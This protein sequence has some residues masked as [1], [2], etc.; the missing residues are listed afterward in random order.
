VKNYVQYKY[1]FPNFGKLST[2]AESLRVICMNRIIKFFQTSLQRQLTIV[3]LALLLIPLAIIF[4]GFA[5]SLIAERTS[6]INAEQQE[7]LDDS[8]REIDEVFE[9]TLSDIRV[10][11][12]D[13][14]IVD[15]GQFL[16][17]NDVEGEQEL[18]E[19][20]QETFVA[21][22]AGREY[23]RT[24]RLLDA[25][26]REIVRVDDN[27]NGEPIIVPEN[28]LQDKSTRGYY[29]NARNLPAGEVYIGP[30][31]LVREEDGDNQAIFLDENGQPTP[32][33][34]YAAPIYTNINGQNQLASILVIQIYAQSVLDVFITDEGSDKYIINPEGYFLFNTINPQFNFG[35]ETDGEAIGIQVGTTLQQV[36]G[37]QGNQLFTGGTTPQRFSLNIE[38]TNSILYA[39]RFVPE[40]APPNYYFIFATSLDEQLLF[41][42][43]QQLGVNVILIG[44]VFGVVILL[45]VPY[46]LRRFTNP[47]QLM[48]NQVSGL[49]QGNYNVD[50]PIENLQR[51]DEIGVLGRA[52]ANMSGELKGVL[53]TLE[54]RVTS[55]TADLATASD[56]AA[57]ANQTRELSEITSL[58][59]NL[60][61]DRF[62]YYYTQIYLVDDHH[63]FA[64]LKDGTGYVGKRLLG[65]NH[66]LPLNGRSLVSTAISTAQEVVVQDTKS[67]PNFLPNEL[68]PET[69][70]ELV[71]PLIVNN[72]VIGVLDIQHNKP[73]TFDDAARDLFRTLGNQIAVSINNAQ[74]F[75]LA[76]IAR[77]NTEA[78]EAR[79]SAIMKNFPNGAVVL[80][81]TVMRYQLTDGQ[82]WHLIGIDP[83]SIV[84]KTPREIFPPD[85][86]NILRS[87]HQ[88]VLEGE[89]NIQQEIQ[90]GQFT[91]DTLSIPLRNDENQ[92]T[93]GLLIA[94][95]VTERKQQE[96]VQSVLF[97]IGTE[98]N[99]ARNIHDVKNILMEYLTSKGVNSGNIMY[100]DQTEDGQP[101]WATTQTSWTGALPVGQRFYLPEFPLTSIWTANPFEVILIQDTQADPRVDGATAAL[102]KQLGIA[103]SLVF[104]MSLQNRWVGL[105][106]FSWSEPH[107]F[108]AEEIRIFSALHNQVTQAVDSIRVAE[109]IQKRALELTTVIQVS[110]QASTILDVA[111]LLRSVSDLTK[112]RF[113][114]YHAHIYILDNNEQ[115]LVLGGGSGSAGLQ[116]VARKQRIPL[117][118]ENS[119]VARA[120]RSRQSTLSNDVR[121]EPDFLPNDL[122]PNTRSELSVPMIV[123]NELIG[124]LDIQ[125]DTV[126]RFTSEDARIIEALA[127][128]VAVAVK[129]ARLFKE[130]ND[131]RFALD[132]HSIV[133]ITD[134]SGKITYAN[135]KL[136]EVSKFEIEELLGQDHK[137]LNSSY[138][139]KE[140]IRNLWVTIANGQVWKGQ[141]RNLAKDG[142]I[143][144]VE[145]TIVPFLNEEGKPYQYIALRNEITQQKL[146]E[147]QIEE[148]A[149][150]LETVSE[151]STN[152][153]SQLNVDDLLWTV[154]DLVKE[155]FQR[156]HV[157]IYLLD[158]KTNEL[159]LKAAS[160]Q[161]GRKLVLDGFKVSLANSDTIE[162]RAIHE[163][164]AF[165]VNDVLQEKD[166]ISLEYLPETRSI[167]LVPIIYGERVVGLLDIEDLKP[168][169]FGELEMQVKQTLANQIAVA[170]ENARQFQQTQL[171]LRDVTATNT[172]SDKTRDENSIESL[173]T[174]LL[175]VLKDTF[176]ANSAVVSQYNEINKEWQTIAGL[177]DGIDPEQIKTFRD[178]LENYPHGAL[179]LSTQQVVTVEN[180]QFY[181]NFPKVYIEQ[182]NLKAVITIPIVLSGKSFGVAFLNFATPKSFS[183][184]EIQL[185]R[186]LANQISQSLE[187]TVQRQELNL[188]NQA[189]EASTVG[190]TIADARLEDM[191]LIYVNEA[192][193]KITGYSIEDAIGRN[194]RFLQGDNKNQPE[195]VTLRKA[196]REGTNT[197]VVL[198]NYRKNGELFYNQLTLSPVRD[199]DGTLTHFVGLSNDVTEQIVAENEQRILLRAAES[200]NSAQTP[201]QVLNALQDYLVNLG[202]T[203]STLYYI[204]ENAG[205]RGNSTLARTIV[206]WN[207]VIEP[208]PI[209]AGTILE[210]EN[211]P[212]AALWN[213]K[214]LSTT[215]L[216][217]ANT[218][219][220]L[221]EG[222]RALYFGMNIQSSVVLSLHLQDRWVAVLQ[223][224]W[225]E[226]RHF[227]ES[228]R[229]ILNNFTRE[230]SSVLGAIRSAEETF[231]SNTRTS[232]IAEVTSALS[233]SQ[234]EDD[235]LASLAKYVETLNPYQMRLYYLN[236]DANNEPTSVS[237]QANRVKGS[238]T[239]SEE[240]N[241]NISLTEY[242][243]F[244]LIKNTPYRSLLI[245]DIRFDNS[246]TSE[247]A[248]DLSS[249]IVGIAIL[250]L[251]SAGTWQGFI[252]IHW[253]ESHPFTEDE[254]N[255]FNRLLQ[256][257]SA[258]V[259]TRRANLLTMKRAS[260]LATIAELSATTTQALQRDELLQ[261][262]VELTKSRFNYYHAHIYLLNMEK[263]YLV[264]AAGAG[265]AGATMKRSAHRIP[266]QH[267]N[268]IVARAARTRTGVISNDVRQAAFFLPNPLLPETRSELAVPLIVSNELIGVL[269]VQSSEVD[270]FSF[271][272]S[273]L[274]TTFADQIA[275]AV[276]NAEAFERERS[277]IERLREVDRLK[278]EFLANMSHELRTPLNSII[279]Y[280]EVLIDGVDGDLTEEAMEDVQAIYTSGK[281]LLN[282]INEILDLAKIEAGQMQLNMKTTNLQ[283]LL[284]EV[285]RSSQILVKD[286]TVEMILDEVSP[287][288]M[289][290]GDKIRLNQVMLNLISNAVKFTDKGHVRIAYGMDG[291]NIR[292]EVQD[293]GA[294]MK[295]SDLDVIFERFRQ[296][297]GSSTRKVGGTGLGLAITRQLIQMHGGEIYVESQLGEGSIFWFTIPAI[298]ET[299]PS[300]KS[301]LVTGD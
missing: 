259:T 105:G 44:L 168:N 190:V 19:H 163:R 264:L 253:D 258:I 203:S 216:E 188:R 1:Q 153:A 213:S 218:D 187:R 210:L 160:G 76:E 72:Q 228:E 249:D 238:L 67:N 121:E 107:E 25:S 50:L 3:I 36:F 52:L 78:N 28:A 111:L 12:N 197:T 144:W 63:E 117:S 10:M 96:E 128:Q 125:A 126:N 108:S 22:M 64:V 231:V 109:V 234:N 227:S 239:K 46:I 83:E 295:Q 118:K 191:P 136:S 291:Q 170:M 97:K 209:P 65:R 14:D 173:L 285:V 236:V 237:L 165:I 261:L 298:T 98:L 66:K 2:Y 31:D 29:L 104:P 222:T 27:P 13:P 176:R 34:R 53:G 127:A 110:S 91:F 180:T 84:N 301:N 245:E 134:Q 70:S 260:E 122:L 20:T 289:I 297:D 252:A 194:C 270:Y 240:L 271:E 221:D 214:D 195:L 293:T 257:L 5:N 75:S 232:V 162:A 90:F 159:V 59:V 61:R 230:A 106:V 198:R 135:K 287:I 99:Q 275:V 251:Y 246:I 95:N 179:A 6:D 85:I 292:V 102:Y 229:S 294:G 138:H 172:I 183:V 142:S 8:V 43:A 283:E 169:A 146:N 280:S 49:G 132:Q 155:R 211:F 17:Q 178:P 124:V 9:F 224:D 86:A 193:V 215:F 15:L 269:D 284:T 189:I 18:I 182:L 79:L 93:A 226:P 148:R 120:A 235:I 241:E 33:W 199:T 82:A 26:G 7:Y 156:H 139:S 24:L 296:A 145:T 225:T 206:S 88:R 73:D 267:E 254:D 56:I 164:Q 171:L 204:D 141:L 278:Q 248:N 38:G 263:D 60:I 265:E 201:D 247:I 290:H 205:E 243:L 87:I 299:I 71:M 32:V 112:E 217:D 200:L 157:E 272:D 212:L 185:A 207:S 158:N 277:T 115:M 119:L 103:S 147:Q 114:L 100:I 256:S 62:N 166:F 184:D 37:E 47:L 55:R 140:F 220:R 202:A 81:D 92:V 51:Q 113:N 167:L 130:V 129:N 281:H 54:E 196:L 150:E 262:V 58:A 276:R 11:L 48:S 143:Y 40:G 242:P 266:A 300:S 181:P 45:L 161:I 149:R 69:R 223:F 74:T 175:Q 192:F 16:L 21:L 116:M 30:I 151:I 177:G 4:V 273:R 152:M 39:I 286:K 89:E 131:I 23:Y 288:G 282:I 250:P 219:E 255:I 274:L 154:V 244:H 137:I 123:G 208:N 133:A 101:E 94:T 186:T 57:A 41:A 268:S 80:F 174:N 68:L 77:L 42:S 233:E 35:F 279:G